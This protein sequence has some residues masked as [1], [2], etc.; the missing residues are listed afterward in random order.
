MLQSEFLGTLRIEL[1]VSH[2]LDKTPNGWRR[3]DVFGGGRREPTAAVYEVY[4]I[5]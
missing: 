2:L 4:E 3:I 1:G 5:L